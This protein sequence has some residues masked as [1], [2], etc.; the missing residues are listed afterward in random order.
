[1]GTSLFRESRAPLNAS[2]TNQQ[3]FG[4]KNCLSQ[5]LPTH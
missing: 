5:L 3:A 2:V 1:V 4:L